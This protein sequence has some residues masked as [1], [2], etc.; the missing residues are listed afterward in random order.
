MAKIKFFSILSILSAFLFSCSIEEAKPLRIRKLT[1]ASDFLTKKDAH[2][3]NRFAKEQHVQID[4]YSMSADSLQSYLKST[5]YNA[6]IDLVFLGSLMSIKQ[7]KNQDFQEIE[8]SFLKENRITLKPLIK[9]WFVAGINPFVLSFIQDSLAKP[10]TFRSLTTDFLWASPNEPSL[11]VLKAQ[12]KLQFRSSHGQ[13][14]RR[15][16]LDWIRGWKDHRMPYMESD[17]IG[18]SQLLVLTYHDYVKNKK[19]VQSKKRK[20]LFP[21]DPYIDYFGFAVVPQARHYDIAKQFIYFWNSQ[22]E[23]SGF[24][25]RFGIRPH[26]QFKQNKQHLFAPKKI[27]AFL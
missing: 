14:K 18:S 10:T 22:K 15:T 21:K 23:N 25:K 27:L 11:D 6:D 16:Y 8:P 9:N 13:T 20:V 17:S 19:L 7:L 2:L 3:F 1:I 24:L 26:R 5:G 4:I 12:V